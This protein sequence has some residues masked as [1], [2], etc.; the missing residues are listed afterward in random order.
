METEGDKVFVKL[1]DLSGGPCNKFIQEECKEALFAAVHHTDP[2]KCI[3]LVELRASKHKNRNVREFG[4]CLLA[5][6]LNE[7]PPEKI[8]NAEFAPKVIPLTVHFLKEGLL[9]T[10]FVL[11]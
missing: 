6:V 10:R 1:L 2:L 8:M 11:S 9:S 7:L 5:T 3:H 4:A